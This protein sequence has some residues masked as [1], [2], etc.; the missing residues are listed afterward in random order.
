MFIAMGI[1]IG[2]LTK[3]RVKTD[4]LLM[5]ATGIPAAHRL[6]MNILVYG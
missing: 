6:L 1:E 4:Q 2:L 5:A 3:S